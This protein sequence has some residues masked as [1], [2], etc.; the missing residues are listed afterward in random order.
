MF[1]QHKS[2]INTHTH[3]HTHTC[4]T[5]GIHRLMTLKKICNFSTNFYD[6]LL[7][8]NDMCN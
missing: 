3:T 8:A 4:K 2:T 6:Q 7:V 1:F 5:K